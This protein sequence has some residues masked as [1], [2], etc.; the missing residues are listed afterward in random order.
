MATISCDCSTPMKMGTSILMRNWHSELRSLLELGYH[1]DNFDAVTRLARE[2]AYSF[3]RPLFFFLVWTIFGHLSNRWSER[4]LT[5][6]TSEEME[7]ALSP[8]VLAYLDAVESGLSVEV[9]MEYLDNITMAYM[10]WLEIER[11]IPWRPAPEL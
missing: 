3:D 2:A 11:Q 1:T 10:R 7:S 8:P 4:P 5:V 9:Q 6:K